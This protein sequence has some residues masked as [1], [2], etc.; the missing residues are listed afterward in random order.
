[1]HELNIVGHGDHSHSAS[2]FFFNNSSQL[3]AKNPFHFAY[4]EEEAPKLIVSGQIQKLCSV[5]PCRPQMAD[6]DHIPSLL[7]SLFACL[8]QQG[9]SKCSVDIY[10]IPKLTT[11][12][13]WPL[14][15]HLSNREMSLKN[16]N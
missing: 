3:L 13:L 6:D 11:V 5:S 10:E 16:K 8:S 9:W 2:H 4:D 1:M 7:S 14:G 12:G 15:M